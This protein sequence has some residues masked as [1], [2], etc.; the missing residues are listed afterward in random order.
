MIVSVEELKAQ[1]RI[2]QDAEDALLYP[3]RRIEDMF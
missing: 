3:Y 2:Q 1:L